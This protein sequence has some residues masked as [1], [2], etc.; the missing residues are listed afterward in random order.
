MADATDI[1]V[2]EDRKIVEG[3]LRFV[4]TTEARTKEGV[5]PKFKTLE[6]AD[7]ALG[8]MPERIAG[9]KNLVKRLLLIQQAQDMEAART[10]LVEQPDLEA[11]FIEIVGRFSEQNGISYWAW[12]EF[13][14]DAAVLKRGG[15]GGTAPTSPTEN[16]GSTARMDLAPLRSQIIDLL[17]EGP[18]TDDRGYVASKLA[19]MFG[20][21]AKVVSGLL[22]RMQKAGEVTRVKSEGRRTFELALGETPG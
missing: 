21:E 8:K 7:K 20:T 17:R 10:E 12:R 22:L 9:T 5:G 15:L 6:A 3:Y 18:V 19:N 13:G 4:E 11:A 2:K 16:N 1:Q 14:V